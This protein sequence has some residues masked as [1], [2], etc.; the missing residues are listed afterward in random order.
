MTDH[1]RQIPK[2][3][4]ENEGQEKTNRYYNKE[5]IDGL[6]SIVLAKSDGRVFQNPYEKTLFYIFIYV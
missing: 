1:Q 4:Q 5:V 3:G 2:E 6:E